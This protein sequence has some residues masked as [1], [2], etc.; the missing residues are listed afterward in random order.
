MK[1]SK[2]TI[3]TNLLIIIALLTVGIGGIW[4]Y[5]QNNTTTVAETPYL[6]LH[7]IANSDSAYDQAVKLKVRDQVFPELEKYIGDARTKEEAMQG[8]SLHIADIEADC[9][10]VLAPL[11]SYTAKP[12][13]ARSE[14]PIRSYDKLV[15]PAGEYDALKIVLGE[16]EGKNWWCVLFPPLCFVDAAGNFESVAA[17]TGSTTSSDENIEVRLK[18]VDFLR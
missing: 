4:T 13:L 1:S 11:A 8:I 16:G 15:L 12:E 9:N 7:I 18:V 17:S 5:Y 2:K 14:F 10:E 6:R 3:K